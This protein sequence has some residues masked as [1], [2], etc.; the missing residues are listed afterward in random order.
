MDK[1]PSDELNKASAEE[2]SLESA[3]S[4]EYDSASKDSAA[5]NAT[6]DLS[7]SINTSEALPASSG[8]TGVSEPAQPGRLRRLW[9][10]FNIYLLLFILIIVI[11]AIVTVVTYIRNK[12]DS[13]AAN[14]AL[15]QQNLPAD[16]LQELASN[17]VQV[18]DPKQVLNIQSNSVFAGAVLVKGEL[19]VAGGLRI[20]SGSLS[21]PEVNVGGTAVVNDLQSQTLDVAGNTSINDLSVRR[22]VSVNGNGTFNGGLTTSSLSVG[23]LQLN[24]DLVISRH[25]VAGGAT[26]GRNN[27][28][29]LGGGGT[30][31]VGGSD[32]AGSISI[33]TGG[34]PAAGCFITVN[35]TT[36]YNGT[37]HVIVT[38]VGSAAAG[39]NYYI[40]RSNSNFSVCS[41]NSAPANSSFGFDYHVFE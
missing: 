14:G 21:L 9:E 17:G 6:A 19:Q 40:N 1:T 39:L 12:S 3:G 20:G 33:N 13:S 4:L 29:A 41:T 27:G 36:A 28:G 38:P 25:L 11:A 2:T 10:H 5:G 22:N 34:S 32:T 24:G 31:S 23:R 8:A 7:S 16:T 18:G 35:F 26:P 30:S 15:T 37:P